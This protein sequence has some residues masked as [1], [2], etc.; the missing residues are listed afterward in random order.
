MS[1][2]ISGTKEIMK[3]M[4]I[5]STVTELNLSDNKFGD[6]LTLISYVCTVIENEKSPL[7]MFDIKY[8]EI[9]EEGISKLMESIGKLKKTK[10]DVT[11][12]FKKET[13]TALATLLKGIKKPKKKKA[14]KK[15]TKK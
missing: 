3:A 11:D 5:N 6:D 13:S 7:F 2:V 14:T 12:R 4:N 15:K 10:I 1:S 9:G 8:N